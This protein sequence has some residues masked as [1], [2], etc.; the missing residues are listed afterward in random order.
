MPIV[1]FGIAVAYG[2]V[3]GRAGPALVVAAYTA[4]SGAVLVWRVDAGVIDGGGVLRVPL[5]CML[6]SM[7][8]WRVRRRHAAA[9][10]LGE[11]CSARGAGP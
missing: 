8:V 9:L 5:M 1:W 3:H 2:S 4:C 10:A 7:M 11:R 6:V